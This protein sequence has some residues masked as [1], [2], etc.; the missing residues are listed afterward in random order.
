[1]SQDLIQAYV[2][3]FLA[4]HRFRTIVPARQLAESVLEAQVV[5][6]TAVAKRIDEAIEAAVVR[7]AGLIIQQSQTTHEA[8]DRLVDLLER[9]PN[10]SV[11]SSTSVLQQAYSTPIPIAYLASVLV[12]ITPDTTVYE[13]T[14]GNGAL[15]I[16]ANP[17]KV[18]ANEINTNRFTELSTRGYYQ[19]TQQD[20]ITYHLEEQ[21][22]RV[23]C[24]PPFGSVLN[25]HHRTQRFRIYDTW[26]TQIDHVI[27][28][29]ALDVMK[30]EGRA[31]LILGGKLGND[32][33]L[34]SN[35]YHT[36]ESRAFYYLLY[37]HY[38]VIQHISIWGDLYRKQG[39]GFPID[40]IV[41]A[42]RGQSHRLL[43]AAAVPGIYKSFA[44]LK[45]IL[46]HE[47]IRQLSADLGTS[48]DVVSLR[49]Q[50]AGGDREPGRIN[51]PLSDT[52]ASTVDDSGLD[53]G[54][55]SNS[56]SNSNSIEYN[57]EPTG[58]RST[59]SNDGNRRRPG[60]R[61]EP[62]AS[63]VGGNPDPLQLAIQT[64]AGGAHERQSLP[65]LTSQRDPPELSTP[66]G[67]PSIH[68][69]G[70]VAHQSGSVAS[71]PQNIVMNADGIAQDSS[72]VDSQPK[73]VPYLPK[74]KGTSTGT[75][76]PYN[77][78]SAAQVALE[79]FE[80]RYG[81]I[82]QYLAD[83][84]GYAS[85]AELH[86]YFCAEQVDAAALAISNIERGSGFITGDQTGVGKGR[87]CASIMRYAQQQGKAAVFITQK[88][89]L[90]A[91]IMR[92]IADI[93][94]YRFYPFI[95]D[96]DTE[97]PLSNG[98]VLKTGRSSQQE[99]EMREMMR[100]Q[101][102]SNYT[103]V[104]TTYSQLQ[105]VG[106]K[107]PLR[108]DFLRTIAPNAI[109]ILDEAHEAGGSQGGWKENGPPDRAEFVRELVDRASGVF[110]SSA[111]YAKRPDVMDLYARRTDLRLGVSSMAAL[112]NILN[113][114]GVPLQQIVAS[115]FVASGQMLRRERSYEGV[116]FQAKVVPVDREVADQFSAAMRAIKDFDRAKQRALK[117]L[118]K[119]LKTE[120]KDLGED[121]AI[122]EVGA[123]STN[124]T[125]LMHNCIEQGLLAQKAEATVQEAIRCLQ[126]G[127]KPVIAVAN[128]MGS[129][130]ESYTEINEIKDGEPIDISFA[131][132]LER[133]LERSRDVVIRDYRGQVE[134]LRLTDEQLGEAGM[135][136]YEDALD[137][138]RYG[139][140]STIPISPIDYIEQR[141]EREGYT[142]T[143]VTG[144]KAGL[145]YAPSGV[146][147]YKVRPDRETTP[148]AKIDAV[149]QFNS[150]DADVII[151]NCSGSTGI[152][153]HASEK[154]ADQRPRHMIV[155][156]AERD[157]N[158]FMQMLGRIH[159][160]GQVVLPS[161]TLLMGDLPSEK[162]P[163][164]ILCR[165]MA[166]LNA[167]T[168]ASRETDIS[169]NNVVDFMNSYGEQVVLDLLTED[170]E[171]N[172]RLD[173][174]TAQSENDS[175]DIALIRRVTGR[176]PLLP[177]AEQEAVYSLIESEYRELVEQARAMGEN[178][179]E[180]DQLDL[181]ARTI[182]RMEVIADDS[183]IESE[184][185][186]A[187]YLEVMDVKSQ[188]KPLTQLQV[189]NA[190]R[191]ELGLPVIKNLDAHDRQTVDKLA[192]EK[193]A[194]TIQQLYTVAEQYRAEN[195]LHKDE[196]AIAKFNDR[197]NRQLTQMSSILE[198]YQTGSPV[199]VVTPANQSI[200]YGVVAGIDQ[201]TRPGSP[202]APN[203]W[204]MRVLVADSARQLTLHLSKFNTHREGS[205]TIAVQEQDWF[206]HPVYELF[207][208][209]QQIGRTRR[210]IFTG[211]LIK[212]FEK[213]PNGKLVNYTDDQGQ[214]RQGLIMPKEFDI[215]EEL[216]NEPVAFSQPHQ[217]R[218]FLTDLTDRKGAVKTLD[219]LLIL[220]A[221][222]NGEGFILQTPRARE[223]GG[224]YYLDEKLLEAVGSD[225]YSVGD[226]MEVVILRERLEPT[227]NVMMK[228]RNHTLA[229]FDFK[230]V[231]REYLGIQ[232][233]QLEVIQ[234]EEQAEPIAV[235]PSILIDAEPSTVSDSNLNSENLQPVTDPTTP[236]PD[237]PS[238]PP[239][240]SI[241]IAPAREQPG[242]LERRIAR[243]LD[244]AGIR[245]V[246]TT[247]EEFHLKVE[248]E[249]YIPLVV[250]RHLNEL[251]LTH[252]LEQ[253]GDT[254]IDSEMIFTIASTGQ[255]QLKET[256]V[257][258]PFRGGEHRSVDRTFA[259]LFSHNILKQ[260]FAEAARYQY[261]NQQNQQLVDDAATSPSALHPRICSYLENKE[262]YPDA[263]ILMQAGDFYE[264]CCE[265]ARILAD[266]LELVLTSM[267]SGDPQLGRVPLAGIPIRAI[268][269]Y[270]RQL[271]EEFTV[272]TVT[273]Q[274]VITIHAQQQSE[275]LQTVSDYA[276]LEDN[277]SDH[278]PVTAT[279]TDY[280]LDTRGYDPTWDT[281]P[282]AVQPVVQRTQLNF[283]E[284]AD[285]VRNFD[286]EVVAA[287]LG[288]E[289]DSH[290]K[291]K[292]RD[293]GHIISIS[294][295]KFMD[296]LA[297]K[298]GGG[299]IDLVMHVQ[300]L[301]FK[302]AVQWLSGRSFTPQT[303]PLVS[304]LQT[305]PYNQPLELPV[306]NGQRWEAVRAYLVETRKLPVA[307]IDRLHDRGLIYADDYQNAV[308]VRYAMQNTSWMRGE[309]T[310]ASLR[311][312]W[313]EHN[314]Y[315]GL[316]PGTVR[317][318]GWFWIGTGRGEI[319]R[320]MLVES[321]IDAL[322]LAVL[323]KQRHNT[324]GV[325]IYL[326][327]DGSGA[328]PLKALKQISD[329]GGQV[330]VAF[331]S[332]SAGE[333]R[334]WQI[335]Q[336]MP[337]IRRIMPAYG[338]DWNDRLIYDGQPEQARNSQRDKQALSGL[339]KWHRVAFEMDRS[340]R[341]LHRIVEV[342]K[343]VAAG[344]S[345][346][347][348][349][350]AAMKN[351]LEIFSQV[352]I[353]LKSTSYLPQTTGRKSLHGE[354]IETEE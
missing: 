55:E 303:F 188:A 196:T 279:T 144:R 234:P 319:K 254:F 271:T 318:D 147:A 202:A 134:R 150:G 8:Y 30:D 315:H 232:L 229:A 99:K 3:H 143:E 321:A 276:Q 259:Q 31:V 193:S 41:I 127:E 239:S 105:T 238:N 197:L 351:D 292:W 353:S 70:R 16:A 39:A 298:G 114:G 159:R 43:P 92:D 23:I 284:L 233:P 245:Q 78:A 228:Q 91:D 287:H 192:Q 253:N 13:P 322:S 14:A 222:L 113:R 313:G 65:R 35:R 120:A 256:A 177:I 133:Y 190:V 194:Q 166:G 46:P 296:W 283:K 79:R 261:R 116:Q 306:P 286:L 267:D 223:T 317:D 109:L 280:D 117:E 68:L 201:K 247:G 207:D 54:N 338:K 187:V 141:L 294:G 158:V 47:P 42:G 61:P 95:T 28:L 248:N 81:D 332:D 2:N 171:L 244:E 52:T 217:I 67:N 168:T 4:G 191:S 251:Y 216:S 258:D 195:T 200:F 153:L 211:N 289:Q 108:R 219:E 265:D 122:G 64:D 136:A 343:S 246:V 139:D 86:Q 264:T 82:D 226:R 288:L 227:L 71:P 185:S 346:S 305:E 249:P 22:D 250:E 50:S 128:T 102:L 221:Q 77:M 236:E 199:R 131:H 89:T 350:V 164:A 336:E 172:A 90:Y 337:E 106:K 307:L 18:I 19:L 339:W 237:I 140:F 93:G 304:S 235:Q 138:I 124:F 328:V 170:I 299:A 263:L 162:R 130:I 101:R 21:V 73:Q 327:T 5:S 40:L 96:T 204:K 157:I 121:G 331:D 132:L 88:K 33:E 301:G 149:A 36:R 198:E 75:L 324:Q 269:R 345:L 209:S 12:N 26:T 160:T 295:E 57:L 17:M 180:A 44:E 175:S 107:E 179:L 277:R 224:R 341:Y 11:R 111:T 155:A 311:G 314:K 241:T 7:T 152:S 349:A 97:I 181:D 252:Y 115:K 257:Q 352:A 27:A 210:Q 146:T 94:L 208:R 161:Y 119:Q 110:Y 156:Q 112:E 291:H 275:T 183:G 186:G 290:D 1:M 282:A 69:T 354:E 9:Q 214:I 74:S 342:A 145:D 62:V 340:E 135:M 189:V 80:Q 231:A 72:P 270:L 129:F 320:V 329:D 213:Y 310:G 163:G 103:A 174:P 274:N 104:F 334:A 137:C 344:E 125:S 218:A 66:A 85:I 76:I 308:F 273:E 151:L 60:L 243:F 323:D 32:A 302:E 15:L 176:I 348:Q 37:Q 182:A 20:A 123:R 25:A 309:I 83:R 203:R 326:S 24:N 268:D 29:N 38:N 335:A 148:K 48:S 212:A 63:G 293:A 118:N 281:T 330:F 87:I 59:G 272:V 173:F 169:I 84:L 215:Q 6:G 45:E 49:G 142:V 100:L 165:K 312:T 230:G 325:T 98:R 53:A 178:I 34:R 225:F 51:L 154:F 285:Q 126:N 58:F 333:I 300:Q 266:R 184:F 316:A 167:N 255:L 205:V 10:L 260:G 262:Q 240:S 242:L 56:A 278:E 347:D 297:D 206:G 220:K